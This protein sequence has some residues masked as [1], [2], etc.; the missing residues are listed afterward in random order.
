[1]R[2]SPVIPREYN[3]HPPT[4]GA[5]ALITSIR[6]A[7]R[8][9]A[10]DMKPFD[11]DQIVGEIQRLQR[12]ID[13][14]QQR[15]AAPSRDPPSEVDARDDAL[16]QA[17]FDEAYA[18]LEIAKRTPS[19]D[20]WKAIHK[21]TSAVG[22][23]APPR[24]GGGTAKAFYAGPIVR[25]TLFVSASGSSLRALTTV[26]EVVRRLGDRVSVEVCDVSRDPDRAKRAGVAFTPVLR[27]ER[28]GLDPVTIFGSLDDRDLLLPRLVPAGLPL[29]AQE[30]APSATETSAATPAGAGTLLAQKAQRDKELMP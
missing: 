24:G 17:R 26:E 4:R 27:L 15:L 18:Q 7:R 19:A 8:A 1:M 29:R 25:A 10:P 21:A 30:A 6:G 22:S 9:S 11:R 2:G 13:E 16:V 3:A 28:A 12:R 20:A 14:A 5:A 23:L